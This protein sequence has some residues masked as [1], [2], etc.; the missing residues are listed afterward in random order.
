MSI[1]VDLDLEFL[2]EV[3]NEGLK[4][5]ADILVFDI[6]DGEKRRTQKLADKREFVNHYP[7]KLHD[8][9]NEIIHELQLYGGDSI[10]NYFRGNGVSYRE[11]LTDVCDKQ[12]IRYK[13]TDTVAAIEFELLRSVIFDSIDE[14]KEE[15]IDDVLE[16]FGVEVNSDMGMDEKKDCVKELVNNPSTRLEAYHTFISQ[17]SCSAD[18][19]IQQLGWDTLKGAAVAGGFAPVVKAGASQLLKK[20]A[21]YIIPGVQVVLGLWT[22]SD[23]TRMVTG[24]AFRVTAPSVLLI[25]VLREEYNQRN[26]N[27]K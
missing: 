13:K 14:Y 11:I 19:Y 6:K 8:C 25:G 2:K 24:P 12:D 18:S 21:G 20:A 7:D 4:K 9:V 27:A 15:A 5:L 3:P 16:D 23:L 10:V 1:K 17:G 22:I 26:L